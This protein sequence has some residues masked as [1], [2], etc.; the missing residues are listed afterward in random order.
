M[1]EPELCLP[2]LRAMRRRY[3]D[4]LYGRYG[5]A[6]AFN[7]ITQWISHNVQGLDVGITLFAAENLRSGN[8]W[9]WF[10]KAPELRRAVQLAGFQTEL[11]PPR[12]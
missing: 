12:T 11:A 5:F 3:G 7:P 8:L 1:F 9:R 4:A 2:P 6:D 10:M